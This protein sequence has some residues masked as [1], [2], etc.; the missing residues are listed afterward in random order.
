MNLTRLAPFTLAGLL[1]AGC[2]STP[3]NEPLPMPE[4]SAPAPIDESVSTAD[5]VDQNVRTAD[6]NVGRSKDPAKTVGFREGSTAVHEKQMDGALSVESVTRQDADNHF[7]ATVNLLN[8]RDDGAAVFQW[9]IAFF[10]KNGTEVM[11][12]YPEWKSK[13]LGPKQF[14]AV[15]NAAAVRGAVTFKLMTRTPV[16]PPAEA[17]AEKPKAE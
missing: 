15:S 5:L 10:D 2:G 8:C 4:T 13:A 3:E 17:P 11:S 16:A 14:G 12:L 6:V 1:L 9:R 7:V